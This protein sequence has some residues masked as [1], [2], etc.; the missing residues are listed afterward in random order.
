MAW[1]DHYVTDAG[2]DTYANSTN[3]GTPCSLATAVAGVAAGVVVA[4]VVAAARTA[5]FENLSDY[6]KS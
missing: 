1:S 5:H 4:A 2:T 3:S 6:P